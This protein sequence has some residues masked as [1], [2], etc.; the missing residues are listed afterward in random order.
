M[1]DVRLKTERLII[2]PFN[3][4]FLEEYYKEFTD[5]ITK[6]QYP[7]S[8]P[9]IETATQS[10]SGF[11]KEM[12]LGNMLELVIL[13]P[14]GEFLGSMEV[15]EIREETPEIGLW[16]KSSAHGTGYG[17][18]AL[19]ELL[20]YLNAK[21]KYK[22]Y[23]YEVDVRNVQ[24]IRL[25]EKFHYEKGMCEDITT[26]SG[27]ELKLQTYYILNERSNVDKNILNLDYRC[28][29]INDLDAIITL[30]QDAVI[31]MEKNNI[32]QWDELYPTREMIQKDIESGHLYIGMIK[33]NIAVMFVLNQ[34]CDE[35]YRNGRWMHP[36]K[37][38]FVIHRLCVN[39]VCQNRGIAKRTLLFIE[40]QVKEKNIFAIRLDVFSENPYAL[41]L[42]QDMG[43]S[44]VGHA[45]WR[46]GR[47]Y[48]MEKYISGEIANEC[49]KT[50]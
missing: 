27:K 25:V 22:S 45:D 44:I 33:G 39:P 47:F 21:K 20:S 8:F 14:D 19:K 15:F 3:N 36:D 31:S 11:V 38:Y 24:S 6:Y 12:E 4:S 18:E 46:K 7:D 1:M 16:L 35:A 48:L 40:E 43:Y 9:D 28:A 32:H 49:T 13:K 29:D 50:V 26:E 41:K 30:I 34:E 2:Q 10:I 17:Y 37:A 42:Y 23:I 5:E